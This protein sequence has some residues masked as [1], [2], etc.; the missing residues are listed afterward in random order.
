MYLN[1]ISKF[2]FG[3]ML[4]L[5][6]FGL[7]LQANAQSTVGE[8]FICNY[9]NGSDYDDL[10]KVRDFYVQQAEKAGLTLPPSFTWQPIKVGAG[11]PEFLWF[12]YHQDASQ[13]GQ[14]TDAMAGSAEMQK[15]AERFEAMS[16][17]DSALNNQIQVY[18]GGGELTSPPAYIQ[19]FACN[20]RHGS[21]ASSMADLNA[22]I[23]GYLGGTGTNEA[24][25]VFQ[26]TS[27]TPRTDSPDLRM[28][29]VSENASAWGARQ[30]AIQ[31]SEDG[32]SMVRHFRAILDCSV[33][34]WSGEPVVA[35]PAG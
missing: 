19:S 22:H 14:F 30:D 7:A 31:S 6:A 2:F 33:S 25:L 28:Y 13:Y 24:F 8:V 16:D 20:F 23:A 29:T 1:T 27:L 9:E 17:C 12:S 3:S 21:D 18:N 32:Q 10:M 34:H 5:S 35:P 4:F 11:A 15:V 26:S